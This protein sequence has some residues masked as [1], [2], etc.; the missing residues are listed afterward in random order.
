MTYKCN[1]PFIYLFFFFECIVGCRDGLG[2]DNLLSNRQSATSPKKL[3]P[4]VILCSLTRYKF[5]ITVLMESKSSELAPSLALLA[6]RAR[7]RS[8]R[9]VSAG[10]V[11]C[12]AC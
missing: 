12:S 10:A 3:L 9:G 6:S 5:C 7:A 2:N 1:Q 11:E 4:L 8:S